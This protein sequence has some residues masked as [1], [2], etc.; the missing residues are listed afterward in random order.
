V[1]SSI[2]EPEPMLTHVEGEHVAA[3]RAAAVTVEPAV[4]HVHAKARATVLVERAQG[5]SPEPASAQ[6]H[7]FAHEVLVGARQEPAVELTALGAHRGL[8][9]SIDAASA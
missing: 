1:A 7:A 6:V 8:R 3:R 9:A 2:D 4:A 5:R